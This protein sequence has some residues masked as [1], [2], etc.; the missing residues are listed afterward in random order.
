MSSSAQPVTAIEPTT[1]VEPSVGV[2]NEP[3][4]AVDVP[5]GRD[6]SV[7]ATGPVVLPAPVNVSVT[8]P[9]C[10][11]PTLSA[12]CT[13]IVR[14]ADPLPDVGDTT[15]HG[16]VE[17]AV[18][19]TVPAPVCVSRTICADVR[20]VNDEPLLAAPKASDVLSSDMVGAAVICPRISPPLKFVVWML[21]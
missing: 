7:T 1:P 16:T 3:A 18:Q 11:D 5:L 14:V 17:A 2:S 4:G 19:L 13:E 10:V 6:V 21:K 15:S 20:D 12:N 9:L 8:L